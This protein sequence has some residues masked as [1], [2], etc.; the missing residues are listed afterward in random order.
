[1]V[2]ASETLTL[3]ERAHESVAAAYSR[4]RAATQGLCT[5]LEVEDFVA[6][7]MPD[8]S[9]IKWH[10]AHTTWFFEQFLLKPNR[11]GYR[12]FADQYEFLFNSYYQTVGSMH[13]RAQR[14]LLTRPTVAE[15]MEYRE[16]VDQHM[17]GLL[18]GRDPDDRICAIATLGLHHEQQHQELI[19]TDLKHLFAANPL[20]PAYR[21]CRANVAGG[22]APL[23]FMAFEGGVKEIG[24]SGKRFCFD[25]ETPRHRQVIE[26]FTMAD[27]LITNSEYTEF[28]REGGYRRPQLWMSDGWTTVVSEKWQHPLYW[29]DDLDGEFTLSG[30]QP[31]D[32]A[33]PVAHLSFYEADAF[34]RWAQARLPTEAE[35]ELAA[36]SLSSTKGNFVESGA[37]HPRPA[38]AGSGL[39]QLFGDVWEWTASPYCAYP[40]YAAPPGALGEYNG[41]FM[42]NQLVLRGGSCATPA[43]HIR[44]TYRNFFYPHARW[45]FSGLRLA[46]NS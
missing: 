21:D 2:A 39:K 20:K 46:R 40:G 7:S 45:Q 41:K 15:V 29:S 36:T 17:R 9:P 26:P 3:C 25:N 14:G 42:C 6:Q 5:D 24:A 19:L 32:P 23:R 44:A 38:E 33:A 27:R 28:I 22:S 35:W 11:R 10:L 31:L 43:D 1:M 37:L 4:V 8:A 12:P 18:E 16:Y 13:P 34:A 30:M